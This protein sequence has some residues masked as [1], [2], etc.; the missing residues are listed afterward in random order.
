MSIRK[1]SDL[2]NE[3]DNRF[4]NVKST[5]KRA[6]ITERFDDTT[7]NPYPGDEAIQFLNK[8]LDQCID[9]I[10]QNNTASG[11]YAT[12]IRI[13]KT[14]SGSYAS[15]SGSLST[16]VTANQNQHK[17]SSTAYYLTPTDFHV[18]GIGE[19]ASTPTLNSD[20]TG[21]KVTSTAAGTFICNVTLPIGIVP[22]HVLIYG[23]DTRNTVRVYGNKF[24]ST[25]NT[26]FDGGRAFAVGTNTALAAA[27]AGMDSSAE[28]LTITVITDG[29][30][31]I[32]GGIITMA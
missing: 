13:L 29:A 26:A 21:T 32:Y 19:E 30:D 22:T 24:N 15:A 11:S 16:R 9:T 28:Y 3:S 6:K 17:G 5:K 7:H 2:E 23:S 14:A 10:N 31:A 4:D 1:F 12:D 20:T 25:T 18:I 8:K 27:A